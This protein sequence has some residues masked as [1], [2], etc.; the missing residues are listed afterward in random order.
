MKH[1]MIVFKLDIKNKPEKQRAFV[2][3]TWKWRKKILFSLSVFNVLVYIE[4]R[5]EID[6]KIYNSIKVNQSVN[7]L[8]KFWCHD[9]I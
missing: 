8:Q 3:K 6:E 7:F 2:F 9:D 4:T 5:K 1:K